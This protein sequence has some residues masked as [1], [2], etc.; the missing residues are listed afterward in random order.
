MLGTSVG[1]SGVD[2]PGTLVVDD[3]GTDFSDLF[4]GAAEVEPVVL[5]LEVFAER[6]ED[7]GCKEEGV[8]GRVGDGFDARE[9]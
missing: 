3:V 2:N 5:N 9:V 7:V 8:F 1:K 6:D 4:G